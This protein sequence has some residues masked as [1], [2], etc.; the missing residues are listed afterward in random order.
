MDWWGGTSNLISFESLKNFNSNIENE[1]KSD[2][3][4]PNYW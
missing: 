2:E 3:Y 4:I 1:A